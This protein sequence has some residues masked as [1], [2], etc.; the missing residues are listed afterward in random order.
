MLGSL[1]LGQDYSTSGLSETQT[2]MLMDLHDFGIVYQVPEEPNRFYPTRL[3]TTLTSSDSAGGLL[4]DAKSSSSS[5]SSAGF[6]ILETNHR[7]YAYTNSPLQIAVLHLFVKLNHR[8]PNLVSGKLTKESIQRAIEF[9]I[10][11][12]QIISYLSTHAHPQMLKNSPVLPPTVVDQIRLWQL[13]GDR[14]KDI[15]GFLLKNFNSRS[16]YQ[17]CVRYAENLGVLVWNNT[18]EQMFFVTKVEQLSAFLKRR[19]QQQTA[20]T[21]TSSK[22]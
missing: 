11:S 21:A 20:Q 17:D 4:Q 8:F 14:M 6:I 12:D 16:E 5:P 18:Q 7:L 1:T 15:S 9:G 2:Q 3:A 19:Q 22:A 13:E 10:T